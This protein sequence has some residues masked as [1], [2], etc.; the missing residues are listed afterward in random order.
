MDTI[1]L[2]SPIGESE[3]VV[4]ELILPPDKRDF[5]TQPCPN[6][7][8]HTLC[9]D[10][11]DVLATRTGSW[12]LICGHHPHAD[13][14]EALKLHRLLK[15]YLPLCHRKMYELF[16][17]ADGEPWPALP[18]NAADRMT[19]MLTC[20]RKV[21]QQLI[22][23]DLP[24]EPTELLNVP[25]P[26]TDEFDI[27]L[28]SDV[29]E[30]YEGDDG[31]TGQDALDPDER[32]LK[33][34]VP[35]TG[36]ELIVVVFF[37]PETPP[38]VGRWWAPNAAAFQ[39]SDY[40]FQHSAYTFRRLL[41]C[42]GEIH[43]CEPGYQPR[44]SGK[45]PDL[46]QGHDRPM[47]RAAIENLDPSCPGFSRRGTRKQHVVSQSPTLCLFSL[48]ALMHPLVAPAAPVP[49]PSW[50]PAPRTPSPVAGPSRKRKASVM[51]EK[52]V[53]GLLSKKQKLQLYG[54]NADEPLSI[55]TSDADYFSDSSNIIV[56]PGIRMV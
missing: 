12:T 56:M 42:D 29:S 8:V 40:Q 3:A 24:D 53:A 6:N 1:F 44:R 55:S 5:N 45:V 17:G 31:I 34:I 22:P 48:R 35:R 36:C 27:D 39:F 13:I 7:Y 54:N 20:I 32:M 46:S 49:G 33:L 15:R 51:P 25:S 37:R 23:G 4:R 52:R 19:D 26:E 18:P 2:E 21:L 41:R 9:A 28:Q 16:D 11:G 30:L 47:P 14:V 43:R 10:V 38:Y 50:R